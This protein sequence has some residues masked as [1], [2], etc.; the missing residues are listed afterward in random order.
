IRNVDKLIMYTVY[1]NAGQFRSVG[2]FPGNYE[3]R[4][5][6]K[7]LQSDVQK[8][9]VKAGDNPKISLSLRDAAA[10]PAEADTLANLETLASNR[11]KVSFDS[12]DNIYPREAGRDVPERTC[13]IYNGENYLRR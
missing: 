1:T 8:L 2:L 7:G 5:T 6:A 12:Y 9:A 4:V 3:I 10:G 13:N 11:V